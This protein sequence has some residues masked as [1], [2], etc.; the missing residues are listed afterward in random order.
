MPLYLKEVQA[1]SADEYFNQP[2]RVGS[3]DAAS[4]AFDLGQKDNALSL[5]QRYFTEKSYQN[6][7]ATDLSPDEAN[8]MYPDMPEPFREPINPYIAQMRHDDEMERRNLQAKIAQG[9]QDSWT[10]TKVMGAGML[11]HLVDP[12]EL[13]AGMLIGAGAGRIAAAGFLGQG[14]KTAA[15]ATRAGEATLAQGLAYDAVEAGAGGVIQSA[16]QE[17][18]QAVVQNQEQMPDFR[19]Y[20]DVGADI[21]VGGMMGFGLQF[22]VRGLARGISHGIEFSQRGLGRF[23]EGTSPEAK[24]LVYRNMVHSYETNSLPI[25]ESIVRAIEQETNVPHAATGYEFSPILPKGSLEGKKFY[26]VEGKA[27]GNDYG[28]GG[29]H[30]SD[31]PAVANAAAT[32]GLSDGPSSMHEVSIKDL[33]PVELNKPFDPTIGEQISSILKK[34]DVLNVDPKISKAADVLENVR[35][36]VDSG[37]IP[38][39]VLNDV[40]KVI[41]DAGYD[42]LVSD[43]AKFG[44]SEHAP[45][46][47]I[48]LLDE[49]KMKPV[50]EFKADSNII[51]SPTE[52]DLAQV[53]NQ[54]ERPKEFLG[55][56]QEYQKIKQEL[57]DYNPENFSDVRKTVES[58][59]EQAKELEK[60]GLLDAEDLKA[61]DEAKAILKES[62]TG[63]VLLKAFKSCAIGTT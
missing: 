8:K 28:L 22:G 47:H 42:S 1:P 48:T 15:V 58:G 31:N 37:A 17:G 2:E 36:A 9:P 16:G 25:T 33:N 51:N 46:N 60:Q 62:D 32:R 7:G 5:V 11:A 40:K 35:N 56:E 24:T 29:T 53:Q 13:G 20:H 23:F 54:M 45:H 19:S 30:V 14:L 3:N 21:L 26:T 38:E 44:S 50:K 63:S 10:R 41:Q 39:S 59:F 34:A 61:I 43:G 12:L 52:K 57:K 55:Y 6:Q 4:A 18:F 27:L 49:T